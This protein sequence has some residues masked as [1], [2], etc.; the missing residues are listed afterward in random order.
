MTLF[1]VDELERFQREHKQKL[2][3]EMAAIR[4]QHGWTSPEEFL[5]ELAT[6][7]FDSAKT[8]P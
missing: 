5:A 7:T 4:K 6:A 3:D 1:T 2:L 8:C